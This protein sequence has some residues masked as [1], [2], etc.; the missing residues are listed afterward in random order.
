MRNDL[1]VKAL[2]KRTGVPF[3]KYVKGTL[4]ERLIQDGV[5]V[6]QYC[7]IVMVELNGFLTVEEVKSIIAPLDLEE[8]YIYA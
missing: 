7:G 6:S 3:K 1:K 5:A 8:V 4:S 2:L